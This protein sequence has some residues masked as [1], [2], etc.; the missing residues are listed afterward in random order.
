MFMLFGR[1]LHRDSRELTPP[2]KLT[3]VEELNHIIKDKYQSDDYINGRFVQA[4]QHFDDLVHQNSD[5][6]AI[7]QRL[8]IV[9][10]ALTSS[11]VGLEAIVVSSNLL[12]LVA[13]ILSLFVAILGNYLTAF[14]VQVKWGAYR[15]TRES[16]I[17]EFYRFH[18]GVEPYSD[19]T[20]KNKKLFATNVEQKIEDANKTWGGLNAAGGNPT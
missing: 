10:S 3:S 14:N 7:F 9:L 1:W 15:F 13:L 16:L 20:A 5:Q 17:T 18:M 4:V 12:K 8:L 2:E 19:D 6:Y 11:I